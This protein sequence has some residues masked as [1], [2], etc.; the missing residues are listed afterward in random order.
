LTHHDHE[1]KKKRFD[2]REEKLNEA[3]KSVF[4]EAVKIP[5]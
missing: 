3:M 1:E 5:D 4:V 2:E